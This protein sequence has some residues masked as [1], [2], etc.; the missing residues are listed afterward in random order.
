LKNTFTL[1]VGL[2]ACLCLSFFDTSLFGQDIHF[3]QFQGATLNI[4]PAIAGATECDQCYTA[5]LRRQWQNV[6]VDYRTLS[7]SYERKFTPK[8]ENPKGWFGGGLLFNYD[9]AGDSRLSGAHLA[10]IGSY[11]R[12]LNRRNF[13]SGGLQ[14][15]G[16][17]R[18]FDLSDLEFD[19]QWQPYKVEVSPSTSESFDDL[20]IRFGGVS[21]GLNWAYAKPRSR[22]RFNA[23]VGVFH[24]NQPNKSFKNDVNVKHERR[25]AFHAAGTVPL[26]K[27]FDIVVQ[28]L[29][30]MQ[31]PHGETVFGGYLRGHLNK[32]PTHNTALQIGA[33]YRVG[34][35]IAPAIGM[36]WKQWEAGF[37]YD[38][39]TSGFDVATN[40]LG[41]PEVYV[42]YCIKPAPSVRPCPLC[43][44]RI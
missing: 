33:I 27:K 29:R 13:L 4:N 35:M 1:K 37:S 10:V 21:A 12:K 9:I 18:A 41:G 19:D 15:A 36:L 34:D 24:L 40:G 26:A 28:A 20:T 14:L 22:L 39:N 8:S 5:Q 43:P 25:F 44:K 32:R 3:S 2:I 42:K 7:G 6:P 38:I 16:T 31:G 11:V 30:Q 17:Q 23:G